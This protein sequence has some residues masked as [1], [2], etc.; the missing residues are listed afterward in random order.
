MDGVATTR[1]ERQISKMMPID[2]TSGANLGAR[3]P[4]AAPNTELGKDEFLEL[5]VTQLKNQDPLNPME[6]TQFASQLAQFSSLEQLVQLN[7]AV[8][9]QSQ[10]SSLMGFSIN[11]TLA[12]SLIGKTVVASGNQ[13]QIEGA[14]TESV[15]VDVGPGGG[16]ATLHVFD[17]DGNEL[18]TR[19]LGAVPGGKHTLNFDTGGDLPDGTYTY[20]VTV[21][22]VDGQP[23]P[24]NHFT[25]A[26]VTGVQFENGQIVLRAGELLISLDRLAEITG[27]PAS[28]AD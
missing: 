14:G 12:A 4:G 21:I 28:Q 5:L 16:A 2:G 27:T 1:N 23:V 3:V 19:E 25:T 18:L 9:I 22:G 10:S 8:G 20:E 7:E 15:T 26:T 17:G 6:G 11:T 13:L 24:V